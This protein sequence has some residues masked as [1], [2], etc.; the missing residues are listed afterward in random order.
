MSDA[1]SESGDTVSRLK[2]GDTQALAT[3]F[4]RHRERLWR[5]VHFRIDRRLQGV[6]IRRMSSRRRTS[7]PPSGSTTL[8]VSRK[9]R[10][11]SGC[12]WS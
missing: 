9:R 12:G 7:T 5:L 8:K 3:L 2:G 10:F 1:G 4:S 6:L 11:L